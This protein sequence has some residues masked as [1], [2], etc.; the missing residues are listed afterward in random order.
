LIFH[1]HFYRRGRSAAAGGDEDGEEEKRRFSC[2]KASCWE[3]SGLDLHQRERF[4]LNFLI[5]ITYNQ[6]VITKTIITPV[7]Y[8]L[9]QI[10]TCVV[11]FLI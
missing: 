9:L 2:D 6:H 8:E 1:W 11:Q 7:T 4:L 5:P 3:F 10:Y